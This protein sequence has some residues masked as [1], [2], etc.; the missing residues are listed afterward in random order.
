MGR[1]CR[2]DELPL[3]N[4]CL[5]SD[6]YFIWKVSYLAWKRN[7]YSEVKGKEV[8]LVGLDELGRGLNE[9]N[10]LQGRSSEKFPHLRER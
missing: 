4:F 5:R 6:K 1:L 2:K 7:I 10:E 8:K 9:L 3:G